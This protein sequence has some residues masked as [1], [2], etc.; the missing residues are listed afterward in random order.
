[1]LT[2][3]LSVAEMCRKFCRSKKETHLFQDRLNSRVPNYIKVFY[4]FKII[5]IVLFQKLNLIC[6]FIV[7]RHGVIDD[8]ILEKNIIT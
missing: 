4:Y 7:G 2:F 6:I 1:M 5:S 3:L 8:Q